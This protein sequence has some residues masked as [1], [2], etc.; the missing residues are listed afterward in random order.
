M[1]SVHVTE[2]QSWEKCRRKWYY[3]HHLHL[4]PITNHP[5]NL[6]FGIVIHEMLAQLYNFRRTE[7][8]KSYKTELYGLFSLRCAEDCKK[9]QWDMDNETVVKF[10][11]IGY[12]ILEL[13]HDFQLNADINYNIYSIETEYKTVIDDFVELVGT[14]DLV[15]ENDTTGF[16]YVTDHKTYGR[17]YDA[18][19]LQYE[20]QSKA[21]PFLLRQATGRKVGGFIFNQLRKKVPAV[22][23][24]L[25]TGGIS[26]A[27]NIDTTYDIYLAAIEREGLDWLDYTDILDSLKHNEFINR[28][29]IPRTALELHHFKKNLLSEVE[30]MN[31]GI[32]YPSY[33]RMQCKDCQYNCLCNAEDTGSNITPLIR[34]LF[35]EEEVSYGSVTRFSDE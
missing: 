25:K 6:W 31:N 32:I 12:S 13:Y 20:S 35:V 27:K 18:T 16:L 28:V 8:Y 1:R 4:K 29:L 10:M 7:P 24:V 33:H 34:E 14:L 21:Y 9:N 11:D 5:N 23:Q 22:P 2:L 26:K 30:D 19:D 3:R 15:L 17:F